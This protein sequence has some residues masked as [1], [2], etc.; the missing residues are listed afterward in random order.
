MPFFESV[1]ATDSFFNFEF[2]RSVFKITLLDVMIQQDQRPGI[3]IGK[4]KSL[5]KN[6]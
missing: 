3:I 6:L 1:F 2:I 4:G 5:W